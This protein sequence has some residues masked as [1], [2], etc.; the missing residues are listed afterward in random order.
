MQSYTIYKDSEFSK[1]RYPYLERPRSPLRDPKQVAIAYNERCIPKLADLLVYPELSKEKR[2]HALHTLNELVSNQELKAEMIENYIVLYASCLT[3]DELPETR[4]EAAYLLGSLLFIEEGRKQYKSKEENFTFLHQTIFDNNIK[5]RLAVGWMIYRLSVHKDGVDIINNSQTI[6]KIIDAFNKYSSLEYFYLNHQYLIYLLASMVNISMY[7]KGIK[8]SLDKGLLKTFN[9]I[10]DNENNKYSSLI[11]KGAF[12]QIKEFILNIL[13]NICLLKEGKVE[14]LNE[15]MIATVSKFLYSELD[16]ERLFS[17]AFMMCISNNIEAKKVISTFQTNGKFEILENLC[18]LLKINKFLNTNSKDDIPYDTKENTI[19]A[20]KNI[21]ELPEAFIKIVDIL[22]DD[23]NLLNEVFG[24]KALKGLSDLLPKLSNYKNP[25]QVEKEKI[26]LFAKYI[27]GIIYFI[28][29]YEDEAISLII[30]DTV[31]FNQKLGPF[32]VMND[33][34]MHKQAKS[35]INRICVKDHH[36]KQIIQRFIEKYG[37]G[38]I[39]DKNISKD[40]SESL[41]LSEIN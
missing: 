24:I 33:N 31:N 28:K 38:E 5:V 20:L 40:N 35:I 13:K 8:N 3:V 18:E 39:K 25:P 34:K 22:H 9:I 32:F 10:L 16:S 7:E 19:I 23:L 1:D 30:N 4:K 2:S 21:S 12:I 14:A 15:R 26:P 41:H 36:N 17:S 29:L 11:T 27:K 37:S 6:F